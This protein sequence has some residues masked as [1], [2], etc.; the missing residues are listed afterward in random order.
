MSR[1]KG[2]GF[3]DVIDFNPKQ[4]KKAGFLI[5]AIV[6]LLFVIFSAGSLSEFY[7]DQLW[8]EHLGFGARFWKE[9]NFRAVMALLFGLIAAIPLWFTVDLL[10]R[11]VD[12]VN[13]DI[14]IIEPGE[15]PSPFPGNMFAAQ[16][17]IVRGFL[18]IGKWALAIV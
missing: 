9:I 16:I 4:G 13:P 17:G 12:K 14:E 15:D 10:R 18:K 6:V 11:A 5:A 1:K 3:S 8:F 2:N 7:L